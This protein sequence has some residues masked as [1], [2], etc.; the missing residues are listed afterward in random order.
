MWNSALNSALLS[1]T[2]CRPTSRRPASRRP[3]PCRPASCRSLDL[4]NVDING[5]WWSRFGTSFLD[6]TIFS[7]YAD[8][9]DNSEAE[10]CDLGAILC[11]VMTCTIFVMTAQ[12]P[13]GVR[14][15][16]LW[17]QGNKQVADFKWSGFN[18]FRFWM[19]NFIWTD[20]TALCDVAQ[21]F[22]VEALSS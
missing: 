8:L 2:S 5:I 1:T 10:W 13:V 14:I 9:L 22:S 6:Q 4:F 17:F 3:T 7:A 18:W 15:A 16:G 11:D 20:Y 21:Y 12:F 19:D